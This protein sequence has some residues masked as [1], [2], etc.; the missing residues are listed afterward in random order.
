MPKLFDLLSD[1][2]NKDA[3]MKLKSQAKPPVKKPPP[4]KTDKD[5]S[6]DKDCSFP[7]KKKPSKNVP[8][9]QE[10]K[11]EHG[12]IQR[13]YIPDFVALDVETTGLDAKSNRIIEIAAVRFIRGKPEEEFASLINPGIPVPSEITDLTGITSESIV[14][15]PPFSEV[16]DTLLSF[17]GNAAVCGH[18][19]NFDCDFINAEL[20]RAGREPVKSRQIDTALLSRL[21]LSDLAG[22]TLTLV[23]KELGIILDNAH[24]A[25]DD[26]RASGLIAGRLIPMLMDLPERTRRI[27]GYVAPPSILKMLLLQSIKK[28][29][30]GLPQDIAAGHGQVTER[31]DIL[32]I[33]ENPVP[34]D[35]QT[36][37][38]VFSES[39]SLASNVNGYRVR[40]AQIAMARGVAGALNEQLFYIAEAGTGTGKSFAYAVPAALWAFTNNTRVIVSTYTKNVQDQLVSKDL[41]VVC[42]S[43]GNEI[44][45]AV[46]KGRSNYLCKYRW[47][48]LLSGELG[49]LS[50]YERLGILPLIRWAEETET[51]DIEGQN[52]FNRRWF[53]GIWFLVSAEAHGCLGRKCSCF[54]ECFLQNARQKALSSHIVVINHALFFSEICAENSFLGRIGALIFDEAH[55]LESCGHRQLR[56]EIDTNRIHNYI[57][58]LTAF[59]KVLEK[60]SHSD[61]REEQ[62]GKYRS[63]LKQARKSG[64]QFLTD[65]SEWACLQ[66]RSMDVSDN[67]DTYLFEYRDDPFNRFSSV[68]GF[69]LAIQQLQDFLLEIKQQYETSGQLVH[70]LSDLSACSDKTSQ[71]KADLLYLTRAQTEEHVF[72]A[73]GDAVKGWV[74]LCG[75]PLDIGGLLWGIWKQKKAAVCFTSATMTIGGSIDY[76]KHRIGLNRESGERTVFESFESPFTANQMIRCAVNASITPDTNGYEEYVARTL[77]RLICRFSKNMLVLFTSN[78]MLN[79]VYA[80]LKNRPDF[81]EDGI[82]LVQG[83]T[84][85]RAALLNRMKESKRSVLLGA[86]SFWEGIDA[87]KEACELVVMPRLPFPVPTHPL[88]KALADRALALEGDSFFHFSVPEAVIKFKQGAGRLIRTSS[89]RGAL[90]VLDPRIIQK[91]YGKAF[92]RSINGEFIACSDTDDMLHH[93]ADFFENTAH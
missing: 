37:E 56:V 15:A 87:P 86:A 8:E 77:I 1:Q 39:G 7:K 41:P 65:V 44:R 64:T 49:N 9:K 18:Q 83:V 72:W 13:L 70:L 78:A 45:Y 67:T 76:F 84:G 20:K 28:D 62:A 27:M 6:L 74:K 38:E 19:V 53:S 69:L 52:Q 17:I 48:R 14:G 68:A 36:V 88:T 58:F 26:A 47:R 71:L 81:P 66:A 90:I 50:P 42:S 34:L 73:E 25:L 3:L 46:L 5:S 40:Q 23:A 82:L 59:S 16:A 31:D 33:P 30:E 54:S 12:H 32:K 11:K 21:L 79:G 91:S 57:D 85:S 51:G 63:F 55:H 2:S 4:P 93:V 35:L 29:A 43:V 24:R 22:Y 80:I 92:M 61:K 10:D 89:D 60:Q 75:V